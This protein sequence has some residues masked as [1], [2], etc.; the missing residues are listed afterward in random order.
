MFESKL[1]KYWTNKSILISGASSGLGEAVVQALAPYG[2]YF[3]LLSRRIERMHVL[4]NSLKDTNSRF[5]IKSCDIR[6]LDV[7][8]GAVEEFASTCR[9]LDVCWANSGT[10]GSSSG[11][12]WD[13]NSF[14]SIIDTNLKG[15]IYMVK[16]CLDI[17]NRQG[18][19]VIVGIGSIVSMRGLPRRGIYGFTK[20]ALA[21]FFESLAV[22]NPNIQFTF[23]HPGYVDTPINEGHPNRYFLMAPNVAAKKMIKAVAC[24]KK[25]YIYP[26]QM[27][28]IY[29]FAQLLP[30]AVYQEIGRKLYCWK[31]YKK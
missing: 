31:N 5:W 7:V 25:V 28:L 1:K 9:R 17:M 13:W 23:I 26:W 19:G 14:E 2:M 18:S 8:R 27:S 4:V 12:E 22:E 3:G 10:T 20:L 21:H 6:S 15:T 16:N 11:S 29:R 30:A 24:R